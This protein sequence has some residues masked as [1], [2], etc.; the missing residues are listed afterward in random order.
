M[1]PISI[2]LR[3]F[4]PCLA[5]L[6]S[7]TCQATHQ[8]YTS[9][10]EHA[11]PIKYMDEAFPAFGAMRE[12]CGLTVMRLI[13]MYDFLVL[14]V[15]LSF[16]VFRNTLSPHDA[17]NASHM[18]NVAFA[19]LGHIVML[20]SFET[21]NPEGRHL[22]MILT[23]KYKPILCRIRFTLRLRL[24]GSFGCCCQCWPR[25]WGNQDQG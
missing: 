13:C 19:M 4:S 8:G 20:L 23:F 3:D 25:N 10:S 21:Y 11:D 17:R 15:Q 6:H 1:S 12:S 5:L 16:T 22:G 24:W 9:I 18:R 14:C 2:N 7:T